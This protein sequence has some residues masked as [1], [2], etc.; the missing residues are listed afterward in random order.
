MICS[1]DTTYCRDWAG[2][3]VMQTQKNPNCGLA[4]IDILGFSKFV[5]YA[6][7]TVEEGKRLTF[8]PKDTADRD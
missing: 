2:C 4:K 1:I 6:L 7:E 8:C 3:H 5:F